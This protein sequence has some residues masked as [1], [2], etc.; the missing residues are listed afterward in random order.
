MLLLT[1]YAWGEAAVAHALDVPTLSR[2]VNWLLAVRLSP[3]AARDPVNDAGV[4]GGGG[5]AEVLPSPRPKRGG[6]DVRSP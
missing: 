1:L 4:Q 6:F 5:L 3:C 2:A